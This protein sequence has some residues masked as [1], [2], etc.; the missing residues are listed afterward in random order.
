M[1]D[2]YSAFRR[3]LVSSLRLSA[4]AT[5]KVAAG[6]GGGG[7]APTAHVDPVDYI[8]ID[9]SGVGEFPWQ[10]N[11][12]GTFNADTW[13]FLNTIAMVSDQGVLHLTGG[14]T[15]WYYN[16]ISATAY[17]WTDADRTAITKHIAN[18]NA[19]LS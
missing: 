10:W 4:Q 17:L 2:P 5:R 18:S 1:Q 15:T 13:T 8:P 19:A 6:R 9:T 12:F 7:M 3:D 11:T 16:V 14:L